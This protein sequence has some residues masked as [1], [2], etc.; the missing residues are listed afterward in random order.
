MREAWKDGFLSLTSCIR[1]Y[2]TKEKFSKDCQIDFKDA[3]CLFGHDKNKLL[4]RVGAN[5]E[6]TKRDDG[7]YFKLKKSATDLFKNVYTLAKEGILKGVSPGFDSDA[8]WDGDIRVFDKVDL[9]EISLVGQPAYGDSTFVNAR[10]KSNINYPPEVLF[11]KFL[12]NI[13]KRE[14]K[15]PKF[16][17]QSNDERTWMP[18]A[19]YGRGSATG[20][21]STYVS[22]ALQVISDLLIV[23]PLQG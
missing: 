17:R 13:F 4:G 14:N 20:L 5:L 3:R 19:S 1:I 8:R 21:Y 10:D 15:A 18:L 11:V 12:K 6:I 2:G 16:K 7:L 23:C 9:S 22:R